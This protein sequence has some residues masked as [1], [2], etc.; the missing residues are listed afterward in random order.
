MLARANAADVS[1]FR[2]P[3]TD[4]SL[5]TRTLTAGYVAD[6]KTG[7]LPA[8]PCEAVHPSDE[9]TGQAVSARQVHAALP[10]DSLEIT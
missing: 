7:A 3:C 1:A 2:W 6:D 9:A 10:A 8:R 5:S 4:E